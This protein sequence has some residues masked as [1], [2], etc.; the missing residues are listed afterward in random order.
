M[1]PYGLG[2]LRYLQYPVAI[3]VF[4]GVRGQSGESAGWVRETASVWGNE[5]AKEGCIA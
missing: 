2:D 1:C 3:G 5:A 4:I